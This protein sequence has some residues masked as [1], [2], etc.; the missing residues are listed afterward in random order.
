VF[1]VKC[2]TQREVNVLGRNRIRIV[3]EQ[4]EQVF[5]GN[6]HNT[7]TQF[8]SPKAIIT[9]EL[10]DYTKHL[11]RQHVKNFYSGMLS[12]VIE[13]LLQDGGAYDFVSPVYYHQNTEEMEVSLNVIAKEIPI[14]NST[15][16]IILQYPANALE[17]L[18]KEEDLTWAINP[19]T[20][21]LHI[22]RR[23]QP[24]PI[25][26]LN[27]TLPKTGKF[28]IY[29]P[30]TNPSYWANENQEIALMGNFSLSQ[31]NNKEIE[32]RIF[33]NVAI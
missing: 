12:T 8:L 6:I 18:V 29:A 10:E 23:D 9:Y 28:F 15:G 14:P 21:K 27:S 11:Y 16:R 7:T 17:L 5:I 20:G 3:N 24:S 32:K 33:S 26:Q 4:E 22:F 19:A 2:I 13:E 31:I 25:P 30:N 1:I